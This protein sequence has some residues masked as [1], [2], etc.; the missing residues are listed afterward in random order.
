MTRRRLR[1]SLSFQGFRV[2]GGT[3]TLIARLAVET[4]SGKMQGVGPLLRCEFPARELLDDDLCNAAAWA[5]QREAEATAIA[6]ML[7]AAADQ[8][9]LF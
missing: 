1:Q 9:T 8:S 6:R 3:I 4:S 7:Q 2:D 5:Q